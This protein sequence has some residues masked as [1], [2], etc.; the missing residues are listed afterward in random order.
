MVLWNSCWWSGLLEPYQQGCM[1]GQHHEGACCISEKSQPSR[2]LQLVYQCPE[3]ERSKRPYRSGQVHGHRDHY[4]STN[5][6]KSFITVLFKWIKTTK[7]ARISSSY[8]QIY[9]IKR[10]L[11]EQYFH[12]YFLCSKHTCTLLLTIWKTH[13][14]TFSLIEDLKLSI[15]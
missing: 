7:R 10:Y 12:M 3:W 8:I 4:L 14:I 13:S 6:L 15:F 5:W 2:L 11:E 9:E 1:S